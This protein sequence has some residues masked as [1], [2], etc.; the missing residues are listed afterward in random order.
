MTLMSMTGFGASSFEVD[1][2]RFR[3]EAKS[4]NHKGLSLRVHLPPE[5]A[6]CESGANTLARVKLMRGSVEVNVQREASRLDAQTIEVDRQGLGA[7]M[8]ELMQV[9]SEIGAPPPTLDAALR[10]GSF[11]RI[12]ERR[13]D[14]AEAEAAFTAGL[15]QAFDA[16]VAMRR[17]E[18]A[19]LAADCEMRLAAMDKLLDQIAVEAPKV[20][21]QM[22]ERLRQKVAEQVAKLGATLDDARVIT[23]I[24]VFADKAD[25]TEELVRARAHVAAFRQTLAAPDASVVATAGNDSTERGRR[26]DFLTQELLREWNTLGSKCRDAAIAQWVVD[27]KVELEKVREQVQN[28]A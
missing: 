13:P 22:E 18:G 11:I 24:V 19:T 3:I 2:T 15:T 5:L 7:L 9:A 6:H 28:I 16:L 26:L 17:R 10:I 21:L 1:G 8:R 23:E 25:V 12:L 20:L 27:A 14:P 4:V